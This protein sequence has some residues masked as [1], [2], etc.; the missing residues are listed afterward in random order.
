MPRAENPKSSQQ[1]S[2]SYV[3]SCATAFRDAA[4]DLADRRGVNPGELARA[5]LL[6]MPEE[7]ARFPDPG[8]PAPDDRES[9]LLKSGA[10]AGKR[11]RRKPRLQVRLGHGHDPAG[12]RRALAL[13]LAMD[14]GQFAVRVEDGR[15]PSSEQRLKDLHDELARMRKWVGALS[16]E[17]LAQGVQRRADA[18]YVLGFPPDARPGTDEIRKRYRAL[19][20]IHHPDSSQGEHR[21]MTQLN[22]AVAKLGKTLRD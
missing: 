7:A 1:K 3:V 8:E 14:Q 16:F 22:E 17:P 4:L 10:N 12:I 15:G 11:W 5:V 19:A 2:K 13:A 9:V 20:A 21:R 18:L 6:L